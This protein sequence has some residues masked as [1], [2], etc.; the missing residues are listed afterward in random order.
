[1]IELDPGA[2]HPGFLLDHELGEQIPVHSVNWQGGSAMQQAIEGTG[3][4]VTR[5]RFFEVRTC[6]R[7]LDWLEDA[8]AAPACRAV[9]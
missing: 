6:A 8:R 1:M 2:V 3:L 5:V 7:L 9:N 4:A